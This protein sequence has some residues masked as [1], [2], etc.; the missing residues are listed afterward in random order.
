MSTVLE[1]PLTELKPPLSELTLG[2]LVEKFG[3]IPLSRIRMTPFPGTATEEDAVA[4]QDRE[5]RSCELIDGI[6]VEK[7]VGMFESFVASRLLKLIATFVDDR[8]LGEAC[9]SDGMM[10]LSPGLIRIPDVSFISKARLQQAQIVAH[11]PLGPLVPNLAVEVLSRGNTAKEMQDKLEDYFDA[12]VE[13]VWYVDP[14]QHSVAVYTALDTMTTVASP[15]TL[16]G[17]TLLPGLTID[18]VKLFKQV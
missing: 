10:K 6:L 2:N 17:G 8:D 7:A 3:P 1:P 18:L 9:G 4:I 13:L 15:A 14:R 12:G 5:N 11:G 16:D